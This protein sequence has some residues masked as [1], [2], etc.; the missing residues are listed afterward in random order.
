MKK[1][2]ML[3]IAGITAILSLSACGEFECDMCGE[4]KTGKSYT[5]TVL[6]DE[7]MTICEDCYQTVKEL[8]DA[9]N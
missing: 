6:G 8:M 2:M 7:E 1:K 4:E 3:G 5:V 9:I